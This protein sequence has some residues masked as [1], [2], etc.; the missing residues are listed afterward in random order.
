[1]INGGR[2]VGPNAVLALKREGYTKSD[3]SLSDTLETLTYKGFLN[4][5]SKNFSFSLGEFI[6]SLSRKAFVEKAKTLR[7][8]TSSFFIITYKDKS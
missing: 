1:M 2:E 3:F 6:S 5:L 4:F 7:I 8:I